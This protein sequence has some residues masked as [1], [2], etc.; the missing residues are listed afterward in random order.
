[1]KRV[2]F[3]A[4]LAILIVGFGVNLVAQEHDDQP[5]EEVFQTELVYPQE[6]GVFQFTSTAIF[7]NADKNFSTDLTFEY[8]VTH[9]WQI[10]LEW[11]SFARKKTGDGVMSR[12]SGDLSIGTKYSFMNMRGSNFHTAV[13]F[14]VG[15]PAASEKNGISERQMEYEPYVIV[16]KDFPRFSR[17]QLFSQ[18]GLNFSKSVSRPTAEEDN[19]T[20]RSVEWNSGMFVI[21]RQARFTTE[22]NWSKSPNENSLYLTPGIVWKLPADLEV[23]LGVA[24]GLSVDA[25]RIRTVVRLTY[26][27]GGARDV[28]E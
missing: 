28:Q 14:D 2:L 7:S 12:G 16:A 25:D 19:R 4:M 10:S 3:N 18:F 8:G 6:K 5:I 21:Y 23:G 26:E 22:I 17:L 27:F 11:E 9:A 20:E 15:I 13:G 1:M 24:V